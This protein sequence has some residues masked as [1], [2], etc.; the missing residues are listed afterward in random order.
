MKPN[1]PYMKRHPSTHRSNC[2]CH[3]CKDMRDTQNIWLDKF[4]KAGIELKL[5]Q[6]NIFTIKN[7]ILPSKETKNEQ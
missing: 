7:F 5:E 6:K 2:R 4:R 1:I 3:K